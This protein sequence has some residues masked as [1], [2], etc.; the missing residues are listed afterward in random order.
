MESIITGRFDR[1]EQ[2][3]TTMLELVRRGIPRGQMTTFFV[4]PRGQP[5]DWQTGSEQAGTGSTRGAVIGAMAGCVWALALVPGAGFAAPLIGTALG[6]YLGSLAGA[7]SQMTNFRSNRGRT[8]GSDD[9]SS[10]GSRLLVAVST[11]SSMQRVVAIRVLRS[12]CATGIG[13]SEGEFSAGRWDG[14]RR[15]TPIV[16]VS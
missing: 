16:L 3:D 1:Q 5:G 9:A 6:A 10:A 7:L 14:F 4:S 15:S 12:R 8:A 2:A 11:L 13:Q